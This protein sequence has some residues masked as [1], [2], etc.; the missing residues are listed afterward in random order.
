MTLKEKRLQ[1]G[2][3]QDECAALLQISRR[4][5]Q[6][7]E[8]DKRKQSRVMYGYLLDKLTELTRI[9]EN[10][11][12][13]SLD[14][15]CEVCAGIFKEW[16]VEYCYLFG[17][18]AIGEAKQNS[19]IDL[20]VATPLTGMAFFELAEALREGL[21][22]KVDVLGLEQLNN[23]SELLGQILKHGVKIYG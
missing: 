15:I 16:N 5:Y 2:L 18:Y 7:Y 13:L 22:K 19:D 20:L 11:G 21:Q 17:S 10:R 4:T 23:N 3:T 9:D 8:N 6:S 14:K 12:I 1:I